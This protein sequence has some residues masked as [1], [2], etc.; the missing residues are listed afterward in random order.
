MD[1]FPDALREY[2]A[3]LEIAP[4]NAAARRGLDLAAARIP[5]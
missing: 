3:V 4:D 5:R 2:G 1:R